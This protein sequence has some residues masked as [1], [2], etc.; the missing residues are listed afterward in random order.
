MVRLHSGNGEHPEMDERAI[1]CFEE[2]LA[3]A[4][5]SADERL[6]S[7]LLNCFAWVNRVSLARYP[8]STGEVLAA[9]QVPRWS[10]DGLEP[11]WR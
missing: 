9:L 11:G 10:W 5:F 8:D 4:G 1:C 6:S 7:V 3:D 2:A